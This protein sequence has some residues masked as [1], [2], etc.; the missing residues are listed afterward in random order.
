MSGADYRQALGTTIREAHSQ[1]AHARPL[2]RVLWHTEGLIFVTAVTAAKQ[3]LLYQN[4]QAI[5][6]NGNQAAVEQRVNV[7]AEQ[8]SVGYVVRIWALV[9]VDMCGLQDI[10]NRA[11]RDRAL[12][13]VRT[14]QGL[15]KSSLPAALRDRSHGPL[16]CVLNRC[17]IESVIICGV[18]WD[19]FNT[20]A[21]AL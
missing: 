7:G 13:S 14:K 1:C 12:A 6:I 20:C 9:G 5:R 3:L 16:P 11:C 17:R 18:R 10:W 15:P 21:N 8:E 2:R 4:R 19:C